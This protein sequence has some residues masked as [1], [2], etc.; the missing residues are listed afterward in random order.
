MALGNRLAQEGS[1]ASAVV[2]G[3]GAATLAEGLLLVKM[4]ASGNP[5]ALRFRQQMKR[6]DAQ[7]E[8]V[9]DQFHAQCPAKDV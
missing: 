8:K 9:S 3:L 1:K 4:Q 2:T 6:A 5:Y 7:L